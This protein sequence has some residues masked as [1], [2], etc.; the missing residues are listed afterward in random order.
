MLPSQIENSLGP[1]ACFD[2]N[3]DVEFLQLVIEKREESAYLLLLV[4]SMPVLQSIAEV[5]L[6]QVVKAVCPEEASHFH[7]EIH[8]RS[9]ARVSVAYVVDEICNLDRIDG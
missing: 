2:G 8:L 7:L 5:R 4:C 9:L 3:V 6:R 1:E